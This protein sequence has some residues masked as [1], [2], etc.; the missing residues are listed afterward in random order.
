[1]HRSL[2]GPAWALGLGFVLS[3]ARIGDLRPFGIAF[4]YSCLELPLPARAAAAVGAVAGAAL[5]TPGPSALT[6]LACVAAGWAVALTPPRWGGGR[7]PGWMAAPATALARLAGSGLGLAQP[8]LWWIETLVEA[9]LAGL[10]VQLWTPLLRRASG[11]AAP[12][13]PPS[14]AAPAAPVAPLKAAD[15]IAGWL[16]LASAVALGLQPVGVGPVR[17]AAVLA[18]LTTMLASVLG[19]PAAAASAAAVTGGVLA[20]GDPRWTL[21][22][23]ALA[24]GGA[25]ASLAER[26]SRPV[27]A[28]AVVSAVAAASLAA[29][30]GEWVTWALAHCLAAAAVF[31]L[32]P[33][34]VVAALERVLG[35]WQVSPGGGWRPGPDNGALR[36]QAE[37]VGE[38]VGRVLDGLSALVESFSAAYEAA[39]GQS[40]DG[41]GAARYVEKVHRRACAACP[42]MAHCWE[43]HG[44]ESFWDVLRFVDACRAGAG[45]EGAAMPEG[46][47]ARCIQPAH[48]TAAVRDVAEIAEAEQQALQAV[49]KGQGRLQAELRAV[50]TLLGE[51]REA[52]AR[53]FVELDAEAAVRIGRHLERLGMPPEWVWVSGRGGWREVHLL[54]RRPCPSEGRC[55]ELARRAAEEVEPVAYAVRASTCRAGHRPGEGSGCEVTLTPRPRLAA[56]VAF[57]GRA[58][59]GQEVSGDRFVRAELSGAV[60]AVILSDGMGNGPEAS[61]ESEAA[62]RL[63]ERA[64]LAGVDGA[65]AIRCANA[66]LLARSPDERFATLDVAVLDLA[67]GE[68]ELAKA[69]AYP[70]FAWQAGRLERLEGHALPAGIVHGMEVEVLRRSLSDGDLLVMVTDGAAQLGAQGE[71]CIQEAVRA[72]AGEAPSSGARSLA[73]TI[74]RRLEELTGGRWPDDVTVA[75]VRLRQL[76]GGGGFA[77]SEVGSVRPARV[78]AASKQRQRRGVGADT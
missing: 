41:H 53:R 68:L 61:R 60:L 48:L 22:G 24:V 57:A 62:V 20:L 16:L 47:A 66:A 14:P 28:L 56:E 69:G 72:S 26:P 35:S 40:P 15:A 43:R 64:L 27:T 31:C 65:A 38:Q 36:R 55:A 29:P 32:L 51:T 71:R 21:Y 2:A 5:G 12:A 25:G 77:Y 30:T 23:L 18:P 13:A 6:A 37:R 54:L 10:L 74:L 52:L 50:V 17:A 11:A 7:P 3:L 73:E 1:M 4:F 78:Q 59:S 70:S 9:G 58:R 63:V 34:R 19:G 44:Q 39:A 46:L 45:G 75:V 8:P 67:A 42:S 49:L 76:D 33:G